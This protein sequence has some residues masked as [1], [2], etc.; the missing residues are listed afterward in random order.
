ML[1]IDRN[2]HVLHPRII[3]AI[4][5]HIEHGTM[6]VVHG[7]VVHQTASPT[8]QSSLN[9]YARAGAA[10]AHFL[11]DKDGTIYQT[12]SVFRKT[13]HVGLLKSRCLTEHRCT[14]AEFRAVSGMKIRALSSHEFKKAW[15]DRYPSNGDA[16]GI[17]LVGQFMAAQKQFE[18]ATAPQNAA[19]KWLIQEV[20]RTLNVPMAEIFRHPDISYKQPSE[21]ASAQW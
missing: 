8:S 15:P 4:S 19:L 10:G 7:I 11:I 5:P 2:G 14:P 6:P 3:L 13:W 12:A 21:A 18:A 16:L 9:G 20:V 17:E 1:N